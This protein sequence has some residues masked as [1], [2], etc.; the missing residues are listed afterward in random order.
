MVYTAGTTSVPLYPLL[1]LALPAPTVG[2]HGVLQGQSYSVRL[3]FGDTNSQYDIL[4]STQT[5]VDSNISVPNPKPT[6][7]STPQQGDLY[8]GSFI[9]GSDE[10]T[11]WSVPVFLT[12]APSELPGAGFNGSMTLN[13]QASGVPGY[14]LNITDSSLFV[15]SNIN[16]DNSTVGSVSPANVYLASAVINSSPDNQTSKAFAPCKLLMGLI[17]QAQ[18]GTVLEY[19]FVPED[20][21][22]VIGGTRYML[23]VI[24]LGATDDDP[25][26]RPYPPVYWPQSRYWQFANRH[27]PYLDVEYTGE[28]QAA[29]ISR[30]QSDIAQIGPATASAQ[31]PMQMYLDTNSAEM[32]VWPIYAFPYATST[33]SVDQGQLKAITTTILQILSTPLTLQA[34]AAATGALAAEQI[35]LPDTLQQ[36]N[37]YTTGAATTVNQNPTVSNAILMNPITP[38]VSGSLVTNLSPN[39]IANTSLQGVAAQQSAQLLQSQQAAANLAVTKS[40]APQ[41]DVLQVRAAGTAIQTAAFSRQFQSIYGFSVYNPATGEA[42]IIEVVDADLEIPD[43]LPDP[44]ENAT[45]DPYYVRV[46]FLNT[47]TCYNMSIIVPSMVRDQYGNFALQGTAYQNLLSKTDELDIGYMYSLYDSANNF[48]NLNFNPYPATIELAASRSGQYI[49][50]N[51]PYSTQQ[52]SIFSP[53]SLFGQTLVQAVAAVRAAREIA[54]FNLSSI[55]FLPAPTPPAYFVCR[56]QNWNADCHLMQ[57]TRPAGKSIYLAFGGGDLVPF[58]LDAAFTVDKRLPAHMYKLTYTFADQ[59][60]DSAQ[61]ISVSNTPY[62]VA[63]TTQGGVTKYLNLSINSTAGTADLQIGSNQPLA[64]PTQIYV[65][66]QASTTLTSITDI[67]ANFTDTGDFFNQ[68]AQGNVI[69]QEFQVIPYNNL[70]YLIRAVAN[71]Q[72]LG[73]V[74]GVGT[75][76]GLLIDTYVPTTT[77]NLALAQAARYKQSGLQFF[78][79]TYTPTTFVDT[80][81]TLDFTSI[82]GETFYAPT[83]FIPI[84][85]LDSTKGF[86]ANLSNFLGEQFWT[87]I[88]PEIVA[89]S[90]ATV[91][92]VSY[93]NGFNLDNDGKPILSL[94]KL[95]F[96]YDPLVVLFTPNDLTHAYPLQPKQ[97]VLALTNGQIQEGICWRSANVQ[98]QRLPPHNVCAQQILPNGPGM[99]RPNIV[100]SSHN[101]PVLTSAESSYLGMSVN[102][103]VSVAGVV[104]NI[105]ESALAND[106]TGTEFISAVSSISNMLVGV[107]FDYDNNDLGTLTAYDPTQSTKGVVFINGYLGASGYTFS[108][109]DHFDVNDVLPS[110][111]PLLDEVADIFGWDVAFYNMDA[112][113]PRQFWSM[114]YDTFTAPGVPN[115]IPNV[116]PAPVDP[117]FTNR[118]RSLILSL[119]NPV[120]PTQL[121]LMDTYSSVVSANLHLQ[122]GV[123]GAIFLSKKADRDIASIGTNQ[124]EVNASALFG[125]PTKYDFF[126]FSRDHYWT[127]YGASFELID[128]GYAMCLID[129]GTGTGTKVASYFIDSDGNYYELYNY[130]LYSPTG[131]VLETAAFTL[132]VTLGTPAILSATPIVPETPNFVNPQDLVTQI[133]K[134]S[135]LIYAAFGPSSPGQ[136]AAFIPIQTVLPEG[137]QAAPIIGPPGPNGYNLNVVG[138]NRQPVQISQ[139]Y[140]ANVT[141]TI[142]GSTTIVPFNIK[143]AKAVPFYGSI[144]HGLDKQ[145]SVPLLQSKDLTSFIPRTTVPP[146]PTAGVY[147]GDGLGALIGT[148]FSCAFQGSGAIPPAIASN[149]TPGTTMKADDSIFYTFNAVSNITMDSTG[150]S[151]TAAGGQY[152]IDETDPA[153]PIYGV[154]TLPKFILNGNTCTVNLSTTLADGITSRYTLVIGAKSYLF[155]PDNAHVTADRTTFTFNA[156]T[157]GIYTVT[158]AA[159]DAPAGSE[160]PTPIT[161]TPFTITAGGLSVLIDVFNNP[162]GLKDIVLGVIGRQYTYDPIHATVTVTAGTTTTTAPLS[163]GLVFASTSGYGYV[164]GI[165]NGA[166]TVNGSL[167]F[168]YSASTTGA[169]ATY[170]LM[171]SPQ[172]FTLGGNFYTFNQD[173]AGDYLSVTGNG[174]TYPINPYQFSINGIV[175][176]FNTNVQPNTVVGGGNIYPMT[177]NNT[178]FLLNGVQYTITL[179][180]GSLNGATISGQFNI[181]Q[182]NVVIVENYVYEL[183]IPNGQIVGNG[184]TYPLTTSGFTYTITTAN[185]SFTV[186]TEPNAATVTIGNILYQI[187]NTTV[188]GDGVTYPILVYRTFVDGTTTYNIGLDGTVSVPPSFALSGSSPYTRSTFTDGVTYTVNDLAAFDGTKYYLISGSPA[189]FRVANAHLPTSDGWGSDF[190]R[191]GQDLHHF[192]RT[193]ESQPI[194]FRHAHPVLWARDRCGRV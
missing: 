98:P 162:G 181:T 38:S 56:R 45:Y 147:G 192:E 30:A 2:S 122:N 103:F 131:G 169:P 146:G 175:Y 176:I 129:D 135:N 92:G 152:F 32:T 163:T 193:A 49:Y 180:A 102:S 6:D 67:N 148:Q 93:P 70:V 144:S 125:L 40:L 89:Q 41:P 114:T 158:Y 184:T 60:Y 106:Q 161:L 112:S 10:M 14:Q 134:V 7:N 52:T 58:R 69:S 46:V 77:G 119:Q 136:P 117:N 29:R 159:I 65:V 55:A 156:L 90:G 84:P 39:V 137:I 194:Y 107:L 173:A 105:E 150:K 27:N 47:L 113:L 3:T 120:R 188:V 23:S 73:Q 132:K 124:T 186:T 42:Y 109:P 96:V 62:V 76:A 153:N 94:Q 170:P 126:I 130:V 151:V 68:D 115:Y 104:Y 83:I 72:A 59:Q 177:A 35:S 140:S 4:D 44:T 101:R 1:Q 9:G 95:H 128:Q 108:S 43:Q 164:I 185:Q 99:D 78:G 149:P 172:M 16:I 36:S 31:E 97:Q 34:P 80:L 116:P 74:G 91:N 64:F 190:R 15:Y 17:R 138:A 81:D 155:G 127:L 57:A 24:N 111:V 75:V 63:V 79:S 12:V 189:Q 168:P 85:E 157:G 143:A 37:P 100:Y 20:D 51:N 71:D 33:Q 48:D 178:Q 53:I 19:V 50:T 179:K 61:T 118:T 123:T 141:Y 165:T 66:G 133:N 88:Y 187:N 145:V 160:A 174:Q 142:A 166:Y 54:S 25:N 13:A 82:T 28:T 171:T 191:A 26:S 18:M 87:F 154:V 86:V 11:V 182:G 22:V 5:I 110:Q 167:M 21:S 183:D 8:F 139:I 121:G